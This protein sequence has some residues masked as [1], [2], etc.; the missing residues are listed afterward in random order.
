MLGCGFVFVYA[1][2]VL[3]MPHVIDCHGLGR[4]TTLPLRDSSGSRSG[5][6]FVA[7]HL[8]ALLVD[9]TVV[10]NTRDCSFVSSSN[11]K[12]THKAQ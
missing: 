6:V 7:A 12:T 8:F 5:E 1:I 4:D 11:K 3:W 9:S 2:S 10:Y